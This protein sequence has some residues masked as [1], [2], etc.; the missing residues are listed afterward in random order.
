MLPFK[1]RSQPGV[2]EDC[3]WELNGDQGPARA[4]KEVKL[5][6]HLLASLPHARQAEMQFPL[7]L[8][9]LDRTAHV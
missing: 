6:S 7:A 3:L 5:S 8:V 2:L 4:G 9:V 1:S